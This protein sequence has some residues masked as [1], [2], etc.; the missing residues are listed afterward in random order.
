LDVGGAL[1]LGVERGVSSALR[2]GVTVFE[3]WF[4]EE[5]GVSTALG[6]VSVTVGSAPSS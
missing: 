6:S 4:G 2:E 1:A 5:E 3:C